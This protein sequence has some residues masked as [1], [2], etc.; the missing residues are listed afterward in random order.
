MPKSKSPSQPVQ[1]IT[2]LEAVNMY[3]TFMWDN[4]VEYLDWCDR[5]DQ[6]QRDA[7]LPTFYEQDPSLPYVYAPA[8]H[9]IMN[10][11]R[12]YVTEFNI[13]TLDRVLRP[14]PG[15]RVS[16]VPRPGKAMYRDETLLDLARIQVAAIQSGAARPDVRRAILAAAKLPLPSKRAATMSEGRLVLAM[17]HAALLAAADM[18]NPS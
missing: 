2:D 9:A 11:R 12:V 6:A 13:L 16:A 10:E 8:V 3:V 17:K 18:L 7:G 1:V 14:A 15:S 4:L 5:R